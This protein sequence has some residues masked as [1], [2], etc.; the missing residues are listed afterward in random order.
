MSDVAPSQT[1]RKCEG[2]RQTQTVW[3]KSL[4]CLESELNERAAL[5][6]ESIRMSIDFQ[7]GTEAVRNPVWKYVELILQ[8]KRRRI[9]QRFQIHTGTKA[10]FCKNNDRSPER[11]CIIIG[12]CLIFMFVS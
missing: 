7:Y 4:K 1:K 11:L 6:L 10:E 2:I 5:Q 8:D 9:V 12:F 3:K